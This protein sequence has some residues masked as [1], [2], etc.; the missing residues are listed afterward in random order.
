[1]YSLMLYTERPSSGRRG[2]DSSTENL[3]TNRWTLADRPNTRLPDLIQLAQ[4]ARIL[5]KIAKIRLV[6]GQGRKYC[7][8]QDRTEQSEILK[9]SPLSIRCCFLARQEKK[10]QQLNKSKDQCQNLVL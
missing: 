2:S 8:V 4:E 9:H 6:R 3:N 5:C 1:E 10:C 7:L